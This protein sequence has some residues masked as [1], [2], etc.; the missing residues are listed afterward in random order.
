[1]I[2]A[3]R[4]VSSEPRD[5]SDWAKTMSV[6]RNAKRKSRRTRTNILAHYGV[7]GLRVYSIQQVDVML[8]FTARTAAVVW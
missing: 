7:A 6:V 4:L 5:V 1:V 3:V 8:E 2:G